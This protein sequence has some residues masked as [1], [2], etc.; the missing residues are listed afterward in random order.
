MRF[1][2]RRVVYPVPPLCSRRRCATRATSI[3]SHTLRSTQPR[4]EFLDVDPAIVRLLEL[5]RRRPLDDATRAR[6]ASRLARELIGDPT[7]AARR[8][9]LADEADLL[10]RKAGDDSALADALDARMHSNW[11]PAS[12][13]LRLALAGEII[14]LARSSRDPTS[15]RRG[16]FWRFATLMELRRVDD[17]EAALADYARAGAVA[18]DAEAAAVVV[19]R[20]SMLAAMRGRFDDARALAREFSDL[21]HRAGIADADRLFQSLLA[22]VAIEQGVQPDGSSDDLLGYARRQP[23]HLFGATAAFILALEGRTL[24]ADAELERSLPQV[25][26]GSGPRTLKAMAEL[27]IVS[28]A[29]GNDRAAAL[30][31]EAM[32]PYRNLLVVAGGANMAAGPV[33]RYLGLLAL[34][35][36]AVDDAI[37]FLEDAVTFEEAAGAL[38]GLANTLVVLAH[39]HDKRSTAADRQR[40]DAL[41]KRSSTLVEQLGIKSLL[42]DRVIGRIDEW[43]LLADGDD[44]LLDAGDEHLRLRD[45]RGVRYLRALLAAPGRE[46]AALDLVAGGAGLVASRETSRCSMH[47]RSPATAIASNCSKPN[48]TP[49]TAPATR[50]EPFEPSRSATHSSPNCSGRPDSADA[51]GRRRTSRNGPG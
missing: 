5:A 51:S 18:V 38:S 16:L 12:A 24:E 34:H 27:A 1:I 41:R 7:A 43:S 19:A 4:A 3:P 15:E 45:G 20:Q 2:S 22:T 13:D 40:A 49:P 6:V 33:S 47:L 44:W 42:V 14:E 11:G 23:G 25:L 21:G 32:L 36:G 28:V 46:I 35:G 50:P 30:L 48:S 17:A 26:S 37:D 9:D 39:A 8:S 29:T 31:F 10:A